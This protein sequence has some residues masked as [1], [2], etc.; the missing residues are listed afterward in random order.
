MMR[1]G[2][3]VGLVIVA[4]ADVI[5]ESIALIHASSTISGEDVRFRP[6]LQRNCEPSRSQTNVCPPAKRVAPDIEHSEPSRGAGSAWT[7]LARPTASSPT[8]TA[9]RPLERIRMQIS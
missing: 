4:K 2:S 5:P 9:T 8:A 3:S 1:I 7:G 6:S